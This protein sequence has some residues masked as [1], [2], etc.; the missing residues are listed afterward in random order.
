MKI[1]LKALKIHDDMSEET[2]CFS[3]TVY[4]NGKKV[5]T[6]K[7]DG[8]GSCTFVNWLDYKLG[9]K[10]EEAA[11]NLRPLKSD[12][13][14]LAMDL[15]LAIGDSRHPPDETR[16]RIKGCHARAWF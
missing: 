13:G 2:T 7:N 1:E 6:A 10:I 14:Y 12:Y 8:R 15:D 3:A 5:G 16:F 9:R 11:K 4:G